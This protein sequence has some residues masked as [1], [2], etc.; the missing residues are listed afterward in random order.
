MAGNSVPQPKKRRGPGKPFQKGQ[1]G[2]PSGLP[3]GFGELRAAARELTPMALG[4]L[5]RIASDVEAPE[6]AQVAAAQAI[7]DRGW[8]KPTQPIDGDGQGGPVRM[9]VAWENE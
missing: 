7:L 1:S 4:T 5:K 3:A 9:V 2:N 6:A 8:G